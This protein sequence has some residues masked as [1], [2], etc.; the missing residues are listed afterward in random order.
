MSSKPGRKI[1]PLFPDQLFSGLDFLSNPPKTR[2]H[3]LLAVRGSGIFALS[4]IIYLFHYYWRERTITAFNFDYHQ[5]IFI[6]NFFSRNPETIRY[7]TGISGTGEDGKQSHQRD[8]HISR[9]EDPLQKTD[10]YY[11]FVS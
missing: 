10:G 7:Q 9:Q 2:T 3:P 5:P 11:L 8:F 4:A 1:S 6:V